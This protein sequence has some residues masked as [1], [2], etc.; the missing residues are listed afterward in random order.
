[1]KTDS[2][3]PFFQIICDTREQIPYLFSGMERKA[4]KTGDY[5]IK[6]MESLICIERKSKVD[7]FMCCGHGR[8]RFERELERMQEYEYAAIVIESSLSEMT[9]QPAYTRMN[10]K[11]VI[12]SLLAWSI[13]Y[14]TH[15]FF[16]D[17][18]DLA[19]NL[20]YRILEKFYLG[21][22]EIVK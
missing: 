5:S 15:V 7:I 22:V 2:R 14:N 4:L 20:V 1:M 17:N 19:Q 13:R 11:S 21:R 18:R 8:D 16:A 10:P 9:K 12:N 3:H 6:G